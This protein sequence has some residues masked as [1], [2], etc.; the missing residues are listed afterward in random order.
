VLTDRIDPGESGRSRVLLLVTARDEGGAERMAEELVRV[1]A[2]RCRFTVVVPTADGMQ[3]FADRL[4]AHAKVARLPLERS[5]G[6]VTAIPHVRHLA[7]DA[8]VVHLNSNHPASRLAA[9]LSLAVGTV[10]P[11][12]SVEHSGTPPSA[13]LLPSWFEPWAATFFRASRRR[14]AAFVAVSSENARRLIAEYGVRADRLVTVHN[15]VDVAAFDVAADRR[16]ARRRALGVAEDERMIV[17]PARQAPNK[18]HRFLVEAAPQVLDAVP[19]TR[20]VLAGPGDPDP[21]LREE[22]ARRGLSASFLDVGF[23]A[24]DQM[25]EAIAASDVLVL[26]SLAEG[27]SVVLLEGLA[28][29]TIVVGSAVG[30]A[31]E[32]ITDGENGYLVPPGEV[33]PLARAVVRALLLPAAERAAFSARARERAAA[34]SIQSTANRMLAVYE[35]AIRARVIHQ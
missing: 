16:L 1:L 14:A 24:H 9:I 29:G 18:G 25:T 27:F 21:R 17:V 35:Q 22:I 5:A 20:F 6:L 31:L 34:F 30:G 10:A 28:A 15:G 19:A 12:V 32:L 26:P 33:E 23:L 7:R 13:V 11:L 8:D 4:S 3:A 2:D